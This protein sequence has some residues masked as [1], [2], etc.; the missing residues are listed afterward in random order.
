MTGL[1]EQLADI[2]QQ[3]DRFRAELDAE[4]RDNANRQA[5]SADDLAE[6]RGL[7]ASANSTIANYE[8]ER[9]RLQTERDAAVARVVEEETFQRALASLIVAH[10]Q[11]KQPQRDDEVEGRIAE[12][13][14]NAVQGTEDSSNV[15]GIDREASAAQNESTATASPSTPTPTTQQGMAA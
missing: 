11:T 4:K 12:M 7:L 15:V 8:S 5:R 3:R 9:T 2:E 13:R 10:Q 6:L 14:K 1:A